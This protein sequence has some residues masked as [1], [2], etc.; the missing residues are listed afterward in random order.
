M[1]ALQILQQQLGT[2]I[3]VFLFGISHR[4]VPPFFFYHTEKRRKSKEIILSAY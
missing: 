3:V 4:V 2:L 1:T